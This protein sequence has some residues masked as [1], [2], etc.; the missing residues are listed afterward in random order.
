M[1]FSFKQRQQGFSLV[2]LMVALGLSSI[3]MVGLFQIFNSNKQAFTL[4]DGMARVQESGR[5][6]ME[7]LSRDLRIAGYMGCAGGGIGNSF[8]NLVDTS[9]YTDSELQAALGAFDGNNGI[10]GFN[11][12]TDTTGTMLADAGIVIG[13]AAGEM[14]S[15][16]DAVMIQGVSACPGGK[17]VEGGTGTAQLKIEDAESCGL[18]QNDIVIVSNCDTA[19]AFGITNNPQSNGANDKDTLAHGS[20]LNIDNKLSGTYET[21]SYIFKPSFS[22]FYLGNGASG[23]P[24]LFY[25]SLE[26]TGELAVPSPS[27]TAFDRFEIAEGIEN[28]QLAFGQDTDDDGSVNRYVTAAGVNDWNQVLSVRSTLLARSQDRVV[29]QAQTYE[30]NGATVTAADNRMRTCYETTTAIRN[31]LN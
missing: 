4:Q 27:V 28:M 25:S 7:F 23:E 31:R 1:N 15:G 24:A 12:V 5:I 2:E 18:E 9:K 6:A 8:T 14:I 16:T 3:L 17:V 11:D 26:R 13:A 29:S 19:E 21:D 10:T 20:N 30:C 22:V